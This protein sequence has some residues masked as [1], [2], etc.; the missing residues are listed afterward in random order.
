MSNN[1]YTRPLSMRELEAIITKDFNI[2]ESDT[3]DALYNLAN[4]EGVSQLKFRSYLALSM[5]KFKG[6]SVSMENESN[7]STSATV[8]KGR[9]SA[10]AN[11]DEIRFDNLGHIIVAHETKARRRC[12]LCKNATIYMCKK[13]SVHLHS[14]CFQKYHIK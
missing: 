12:K 6:T 4:R 9:P 10:L 2:A 5:I 1:Y 8:N 14:N 13:C 7:A 3:I 11:I